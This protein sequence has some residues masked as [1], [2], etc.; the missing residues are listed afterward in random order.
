MAE[1]SDVETESVCGRPWVELDFEEVNDNF[2]ILWMHLT[3]FMLQWYSII[4]V[5]SHS[6]VNNK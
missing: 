3:D 6:S 5:N 2:S 1:L 4:D